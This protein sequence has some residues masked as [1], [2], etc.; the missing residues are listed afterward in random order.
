M[1]VN[2]GGGS[3]HFFVH[4]RYAVVTQVIP[5]QTPGGW[6][7]AEESTWSFTGGSQPASAHLHH[8]VGVADRPVFLQQARLQ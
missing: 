2:G 4:R 6:P 5:A 1:P 7:V 3:S 8:A